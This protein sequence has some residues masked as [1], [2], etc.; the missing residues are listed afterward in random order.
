M[1]GLRARAGIREDRKHR[2]AGRNGLTL[3][4]P[5]VEPGAE[6]M[7]RES[8]ALSVN[9]KQ[10][11]NCSVVTSTA[12]GQ[13]VGVERRTQKGPTVR[14]RSGDDGCKGERAAGDTQ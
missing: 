4:G 14:E 11:E 13:R 10:G 9:Q 5:T 1:S 7:W 2:G 8:T 3:P 12:W 6:E